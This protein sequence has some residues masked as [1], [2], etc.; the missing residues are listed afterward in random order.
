MPIKGLTDR[1]SLAPRFPRLGKLK[2]GEPKKEKAYARDLDYFRFATEQSEI[3][4]AFV[5][6]YGKA[7]NRLGVYLPYAKADENF[8]TWMEEWSAGG[9][10]H[11]CDGETMTMHRM[12]DGSFSSDSEPCPY[13]TGTR[14]RTKKKP[15]CQIIGRLSVI[16]PALLHAGFVGYVTLETHSNHDVR[17]VMSSLLETERHRPQGL[18]GIPFTIWRQD[19]K[20]S[21]PD[22]NGGRARRK[23]SLV[24]I[25]P[26]REWIQSRIS[27]DRAEA[28]KALPRGDDV[29]Y[30]ID[31]EYSAAELVADENGVIIIGETE[32]EVQPDIE[33]DP[34]WATG[35][36]T[37]K[38]TPFGDL[39]A[40]QLQVVIDSTP[41]DSDRNIAAKMLIDIMIDERKEEADALEQESVDAEEIGDSHAAFD[42]M[43]GG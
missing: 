27:L 19:E 29:D 36:L 10:V 14:V 43:T 22:G 13:I 25:A 11:R 31:A 16:L 17:S 39:N 15:G 5:D 9:L 12:T 18:Q 8:D 42:E 24:K 38:G 34:L 6:A 35:I 1:E 26:E 3:M 20:I 30:V 32:A 41:G 23:K 40:D 28:F 2:K 33:M 21:T 7:P 4:S 37:P